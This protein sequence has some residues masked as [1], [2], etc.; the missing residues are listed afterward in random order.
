MA[1]CSHG[2]EEKQ[3]SKTNGKARTNGAAIMLIR[4]TLKVHGVAVMTRPLVIGV[5]NLDVIYLLGGKSKGANI[6]FKP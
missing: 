5:R 2:T 3:I 6:L 1:L 4:S